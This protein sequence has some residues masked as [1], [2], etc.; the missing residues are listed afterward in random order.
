MLSG[1]GP[2]GAVSFAAAHARDALPGARAD[3]AVAPLS[4]QRLWT[5]LCE[6]FGLKGEQDILPLLHT[7][8]KKAHVASFAAVVAGGAL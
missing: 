3:A 1:S 6:H 5:L 8:F 7:E 4:P 2:T